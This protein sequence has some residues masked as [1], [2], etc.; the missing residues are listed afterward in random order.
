MKIR[1]SAVRRITALILSAALVVPVAFSFPSESY[2]S[3]KSNDTEAV[4]SLAYNVFGADVHYYSDEFFKGD[5][6]PYNVSLAAL[7]YMICNMTYSSHGKTDEECRNLREFLQDNGFVDFDVNDDYK[8]EASLETS[9]V[10]CAHKTIT[11]NGK[12]YTLLA[13][14]PRSGTFGAEFERSLYL[15]KNANDVGDHAGYDACKD[16]VVDYVRKYMKKYGIKGDLKVWTTGYSGGGGVSNLFSAELIRYPSY[17]LGNPNFKAS[18]LY[19]YCFSPMRAAAVGSDPKN[20]KYDCIHNV[21]DDADLLM[22]LPT[23][24]SFDRYGKVYKYRE[25]ATKEDALK[26]MQADNVWIYNSYISSQDPDLFNTYKPDAEKLISE[27]KLETVPDPDSYL[28]DDKGKPN[29]AVYLNGVEDA[30]ISVCEQAGGGNGRKGF[31]N[32]Y[33]EP[34]MALVGFFFRDGI[35][36]NGLKVLL[37]AFTGTKTSIPLVLSMYTSFMVNKSIND[38]GAAFDSLIEQSFNRLASEIENEDGSL[39]DRYKGFSAYD[40]IVNTYFAENSDASEGK[41]HLVKKFS[42]SEK[43][44]LLQKLKELTGVLYAASFSEALTAAGEDEDTI[45]RLT[46]EDTSEASAF[47]LANILFGNGMQSKK[48]EPL[49]PDNEQFCQLATFTGNMYIFITMHMFYY[50]MDWCRAADP[51]YSD[52]AKGT[53]A[54][55]TGYRRLFISQPSD[56]SVSGIVTDGS[57]N[58]VASFKDGRLLS[59]SDEWIGITTSDNGNWLRLPLDQSYSVK[60]S[61]SEDAAISLRVADYSIGD[62]AELRSVTSDK[63][64]SWTGLNADSDDTLVLS[65]PAVKKNGEAYDLTSADYTLSISKPQASDGQSAGSGTA[66]AETYVYSKSVPA[67]KSV[68]ASAG[69]KCITVKWKK[70]S[71]K[72]RKKF[73]RVQIQYSTSRDFSNAKTYCL[74]QMH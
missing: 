18:D 73:G 47:F 23:S 38:G 16:K 39:K 56:A 53:A 4:K 60:M 50:L 9:A 25:N 61:V 21:L 40:Y 74:G 70:L 35:N 57:G 51:Y 37:N 65:I 22:K 72:Q 66:A 12:E 11:D 24:D 67:V 71:A 41:Y 45:A 58:T 19:S 30:I 13:V 5:S 63:N 59:R 34:M 32:E 17:V 44:L 26:M 3:V 15:S 14:I 54:Q 69:K 7:S 33:Q 27:G 46:E 64:S 49:K 29:Q 43:S 2:A 55:I 48:T 6:E 31:Y 36:Y 68:R 20:S 42:S 1:S 10:A 62:G 52:F 8:E 28:L